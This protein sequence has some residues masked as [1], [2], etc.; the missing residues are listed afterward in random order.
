MSQESDPEAAAGTDTARCPWHAP[1]PVDEL[2]RSAWT[3]EERTA[4]TPEPPRAFDY[5]EA[6]SRHRGLITPEEQAKLRRSR[7]AIIGMGGVGGIHLVTLARMGVGKFTIADPDT[8]ELANFNRQYGAKMSTLG[9]HKVDV[10]AEEARDINPE[11]DV[12]VMREAVTEQN[13]DEFLDGADILVDGVD[14]FAIEARRTV[15]RRAREK[16]LW[17]VTAGPHGFGTSWF[18]FDPRGMAFDRFFDFRDGQTEQEKIVAFAVGC[19]PAPLHLKYIDFKKFFSTTAKAGGSSSSGCAAASAVIGTTVGKILLNHPGVRPAPHFAHFDAY[20]QKTVARTCRGGNRGLR[21]RLK[22]RWLLSKMRPPG[23]EGNA[24][25]GS[26]RELRRDP[27]AFLTGLREYGDIASFRVG[28]RRIYMVHTPELVRE[29]LV[30]QNRKFAKTGI[31]LQ[32]RP[33]L[34]N[35]LLTSEGDLH[36]RQRRLMQPPMHP[37][38]IDQYVPTIVRLT[39]KTRDRYRHGSEIDLFDEMLQLTIK[40]VAETMLGVSLDGE[41]AELERAVTVALQYFD[42][43]LSPSRSRVLAALPTQRN[44]RYKKAERCLKKFVIDLITRRRAE[45]ARGDDV[46]SRLVRAADSESGEPVDDRQIRDEII[47]LIAAGHETIA[48]AMTWT[49]HL[50]AAHP[51]VDERLVAEIED[52]L[53]DRLPTADDLSKLPFTRAVLLESMRLYP[54][55]WA[56]SRKSTEDCDLGG[57][58]VP[59]GTVVGVS[60]YVMQRDE[61]YWDEPEEFRP[62][63]WLQLA[64]EADRNRLTSFPFGAGPRVCIGKSMAMTE[65]MIILATLALRW[66]FVT[67]KPLGPSKPLIVL[68]PPRVRFT[69]KKRPPRRE[70]EGSRDPMSIKQ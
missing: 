25:L 48:T 41:A 69:V 61:R 3:P 30:T 65:G 12:K 35:G 9:R 27:L 18:A 51:R 33:L 68:R 24:V 29:V 4:I 15:F 37:K 34:G 42:R 60:Q 44:R 23:P 14:F 47:T 40:I 1:L 20:R 38:V 36:R 31:I 55:L 19:V 62:E 10:M 7:V 16:G 39:E 5:H 21:Q 49:W 45:G 8:F 28:R 57:F 66:R 67:D 52:V 70:T 64:S 54:P 17:A 11:I 32:A 59:A 2:R 13:V 63:R 43:L 53:S 6:F 22:R 58:H 56:L 26:A 46:L 50:L